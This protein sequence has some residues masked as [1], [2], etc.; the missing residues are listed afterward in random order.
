[1]ELKKGKPWVFV[2]WICGFLAGED[3]CGWAPW[4]KSRFTFEKYIRPNDTFDK[5]R[6]TREHNEMVA[7]HAAELEAEGYTVYLEGQNE[8]AIEGKTATLSCKPDIVAVK[9]TESDEILDPL[10]GRYV[11]L[12]VDCKT[13]R[14]RRK[15]RW[16]VAI[17][18]F[19]YT[20]HEHPG[21]PKGTPVHGQ[22][23]YRRRTSTNVP[24][25]DAASRQAVID[26]LLKM[27]DPTPPKR[28][29]SSAECAYCEIGE[30]PDRVT[31]KPMSL[32]SEF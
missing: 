26:T 4:V 29:P 28:M 23:R 20:I 9:R 31:A 5:D 19:G 10:R 32:T 18:Q 12:V 2:T 21:F 7:E 24:P 30:C 27:G 3:Q 13:G 8:F 16:Q 25:L 6:W 17:Y 1:M 15:D 14:E 22:V 11:V